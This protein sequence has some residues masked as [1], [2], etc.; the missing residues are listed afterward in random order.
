M[1]QQLNLRTPWHE[2]KEKLKENDVNLTDED[3]EYEPGREEQLLERLQ[4]KM[5]KDKEEIRRYIESVASNE[6]KAG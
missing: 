6:S 2:V 1:V 5:H 3:L 4:E